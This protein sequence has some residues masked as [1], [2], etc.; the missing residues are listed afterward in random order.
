MINIR[1]FQAV[2]EN[3]AVS[4]NATESHVKKSLVLSE[5]VTLLSALH[6]DDWAEVN[7][8]NPIINY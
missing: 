4:Q 3:S 8:K 2:I 7:C 5:D 1:I 6:R